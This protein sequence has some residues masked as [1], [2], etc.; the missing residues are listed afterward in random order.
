MWFWCLQASLD[1]ERRYSCFVG[2]MRVTYHGLQGDSFE[3]SCSHLRGRCEEMGAA[4][5][6]GR[7][8]AWGREEWSRS[9]HAEWRGPQEERGQRRIRGPDGRRSSHVS[10]HQGAEWGRSLE[11]RNRHKRTRMK[12]PRKAHSPR[13]GSPV[14]RERRR[15]LLQYLQAG[16]TVGWSARGTVG[17][18]SGESLGSRARA[19]I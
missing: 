14:R 15:S 13:R 5:D 2:E 18:S 7:W 4:E 3:R 19:L 16:V 17:G 9:G 12:S 11:E 6:R 1:E 10:G 8:R